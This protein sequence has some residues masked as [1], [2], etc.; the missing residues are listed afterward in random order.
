MGIAIRTKN[1]RYDYLIMLIISTIAFGNVGGAFQIIRI[2]AILF[3]PFLL[4]NFQFIRA[5]Y[6]LLMFFSFWVLFASLSFLWTTNTSEGV[7]HFMYLI[8]HIL[9][10]LELLFLSKKAS[11]PLKSIML[12]WLF[13]VLI[14]LPIA[15]NEIINDAHLSYSMSE[16]SEMHNTGREVYQKIFA[17]VTFYIYNDYSMHLCL[18]VPFVMGLLF[19]NI[20]KKL[21]FTVVIVLCS[22]M[23]II[24]VNSSRGAM[25][26]LLL[27][28]ILF[29]FYY[30]KSKVRYKN[31]VLALLI[32]LAIVGVV[33]I[34]D[35]LFEQL[36]YRFVTKSG[37]FDDGH[38]TLL[39]KYSFV[40]LCNTLFLG[41]GTGG[42]TAA[43]SKYYEIHWPHNIILEI[44]LEYGVFI[45]LPILLFLIKVLGRWLKKEGNVVNK[46]I[47]E[48]LLITLPLYGTINSHYVTCPGVW[49]MFVSLLIFS[50]K[51]GKSS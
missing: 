8:C 13:F 40:I 4:S 22:M 44:W 17:S 2:L 20:D 18:A 21:F 25:L 33:V 31:M 36:S 9:L 7:K 49:V 16:G 15:F 24:L 11:N 3:L 26:C 32:L 14:T 1:N 12:G 19:T 27:A 37:V 47:L 51:Y 29:Y 42:V 34:G 41:V 39:I 30:R 10:F 45:M 43:L 46:Y 48:T 6:K 23:Y 5:N 28:T 50:E 38:R 35:A